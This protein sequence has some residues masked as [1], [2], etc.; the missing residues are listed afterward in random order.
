MKQCG[1]HQCKRKCCDGSNISC[2]VC[3]EL[4]DKLL[5]CKN[6]KCTA[7]CGHIGSCSPCTVTLINSCACGSTVKQG[8]FNLKSLLEKIITGIFS[9]LWS[10]KDGTSKM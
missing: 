1:K 6:H 10:E 3:T 5:P 2:A 8:I 9:T 7:P 4:C